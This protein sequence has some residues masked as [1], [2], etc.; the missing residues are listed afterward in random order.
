MNVL[1]LLKVCHRILKKHLRFQRSIEFPVTS[2]C[3][4]LSHGRQSCSLETPLLFHNV[5]QHWCKDFVYLCPFSSLCRVKSVA[6]IQTHSTKMWN[7]TNHPPLRWL[8]LNNLI[9]MWKGFEEKF[10]FFNIHSHLLKEKAR[11]TVSSD[12]PPTIHFIILSWWPFPRMPS[13]PPHFWIGMSRM[14]LSARLSTTKE[15]K[16]GE[17][18]RRWQMRESKKALIGHPPVKTGSLLLL[19]P[20]TIIWNFYFCKTESATAARI[21]PKVGRSNG[22]CLGNMALPPR[23]DESAP[24]PP[25]ILI[26]DFMHHQSWPRNPIGSFCSLYQREPTTSG[27]NQRP[28]A[29]SGYHPFR[30]HWGKFLSRE[31]IDSITALPLW[32]PRHPF[33]ICCF[34][35]YQEEASP[36]CLSS[37]IHSGFS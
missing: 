6:Y 1:L 8:T 15:K 22:K 9:L 29:Q 2:A 7:N 18:W 23:D 4:G 10:Y 31:L 12:V 13:L 28:M 21:S 32:F 25:P 30:K 20:E 17:E 35:W 27:I 5:P 33:F 26:L 11:A 19:L 24:P 34:H 3:D 37:R 36:D 14:H 16:G